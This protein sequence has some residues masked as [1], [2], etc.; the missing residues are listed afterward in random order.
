VGADSAPAA[1]AEAPVTGAG[2]AGATPQAAPIDHAELEAKLRAERDRNMTRAE[3]KRA[4]VEREAAEKARAEAEAEAKKWQGVGKEKSWLETIKATGRNPSEVF[5]EMK[6]EALKAGT[7]EA[8]LEALE[9]L[10]A[11]RFETLEKT[12]KEERDA[13]E[14]E[15]QQTTAQQ[16]H[17]RFVGDFQNGVMRDEFA[18][19]REE[20]EAPQLFH[21]VNVLKN[22]PP[23]LMQQ[24]KTLG[25]KLTANDGTFT[26]MDILNVMKA[27]QAR[28]FNRIEEQRRKQS[29]ASQAS[30]A[31]PQQAPAATKPTV[32]GT[33]ERNAGQTIGNDLAATTAAGAKPPKKETR[34]E[35]VARLSNKYG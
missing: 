25:V 33:A 14:Q 30:S 31:A 1:P 6:N 29:A 32:N 19:L 24:A 22:N 15:R 5:E 18:P 20:Y 26:M 11:E 12:I 35:R 21:F 7:P 2:D 4:K 8:K 34:E 27:Q 16:Q 10:Y 9:R 17:A 23:Y 3:R 28:H 13:R